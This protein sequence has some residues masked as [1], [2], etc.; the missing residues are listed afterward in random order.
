MS[1]KKKIEADYNNGVI[2]INKLQDQRDFYNKLSKEEKIEIDKKYGTETEKTNNSEL[3]LKDEVEKIENSFTALFYF[4]SILVGLL[5]SFIK[6]SIDSNGD[7]SVFYRPFTYFF[8]QLF[9]VCII[10]LIFS[11]IISIFN[12]KSKFIKI[13]FWTI[14]IISS[15]AIYAFI[16]QV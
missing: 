9:T 5:Y 6:M 4:L 13:F 14:F 3:N 2:S 15:L 1:H 11:G 12:K 10:S 16:S 8:I 7:F